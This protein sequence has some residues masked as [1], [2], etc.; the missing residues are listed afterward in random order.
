MR[1]QHVKDYIKSLKIEAEKENAT[2]G[3]Q[4]KQFIKKNY[5]DPTAGFFYILGCSLVHFSL[6]ISMYFVTWP[7][8]EKAREYDR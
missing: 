1:N 6:F 3:S 8:V 4:K 5:I 2:Y 7:N